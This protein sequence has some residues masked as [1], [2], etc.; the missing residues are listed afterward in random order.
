VNLKHFAMLLTSVGVLGACLAVPSAQAVNRSTTSVQVECD[1][2]YPVCMEMGLDEGFCRELA[3]RMCS[4]G[5][6]DGNN[7]P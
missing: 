2:F 5:G 6:D 3:R 4:V 7:Q 1:D